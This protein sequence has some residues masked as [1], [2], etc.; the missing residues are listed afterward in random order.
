MIRKTPFINGEFYHIYNRGVD[1]RDVFF[2]AYDVERFMQSLEEFNTTEPIGSIYEHSFK[3]QKSLGP[4]MS[5]LVEIVC[6]CI[7]PNHYHFILKQISDN[8]ISRLM[9][10]LGGYT[11]YV[12]EKYERSGALFQGGF[13]AIHINS[14][15]YLLHLSAYVN[16]NDRVHQLG[17]PMS[18]LVASSWGEYINNHQAQAFCKKDIILGQFNDDI[19][20]YKIFA[21]ETIEGII[22]RRMED[23]KLDGLLLE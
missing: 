13:K 12:N 7:N 20:A 3:K 8:G 4:P 9:Q 18:K 15:E 22:K 17:H 1:K 6:Y 11:K 23:K 10:R 2:D 14:N 5:K 16:L 21:E 19:N